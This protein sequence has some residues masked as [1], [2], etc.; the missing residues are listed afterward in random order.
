MINSF[1]FLLLNNN[2]KNI[3]ITYL[4]MTKKR[5]HVTSQC[6][7]QKR[8]MLPFFLK[9]KL[10]FKLSKTVNH[11]I[12]YKEIKAFTIN[13]KYKITGFF[14][15]KIKNQ[16]I[17]T[18]NKQMFLDPSKILSVQVVNECCGQLKIVD[19]ITGHAPLKKVKWN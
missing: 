16:K 14:F 4:K 13:L 8:S 19:L 18:F 7:I 1:W 11:P 2:K 15:W 17:N 3:E 10:K 6:S 9:I 5:L 12:L